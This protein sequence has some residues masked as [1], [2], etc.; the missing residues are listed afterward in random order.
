MDRWIDEANASL[1]SNE[2]EKD[3]ARLVQ[4]KQSI[5]VIS[6]LSAA[7]LLSACGG[8][9][10]G[11][12]STPT[13]PPA[14]AP[15]PTPTPTPPPAPPPPPSTE[16]QN[17]IVAVGM[18]AN[19]AY[20]KGI[21]GSGVLIAVLD[22]GIDV[23]NSEFAG[24]LSA[25]SKTFSVRTCISNCDNAGAVYET[26]TPNLQD[27]V[28]HGTAVSS[29]AAANADA[30]GIQGVAPGATIL[31]LKNA[32]G[33]SMSSLTATVLNYALDKGAFVLN[34]S[35]LVRGDFPGTCD[36]CTTT[37]RGVMDRFASTNSLYVQSVSNT[38]G[39][40][41][42]AG[43]NV[44][45]MLGDNLKNKEYFLF[46]I[47]AEIAPDQQG[48]PGILTD[49]TLAVNAHRIQ[50][51]KIGGGTELATGNSFAAP[52]IAGAAALLKQY[53]PQLGGKEISQVLLD[54][55]DAPGGTGNRSGF[56]MLNMQTAM[57]AQAPT[58]SVAQAQSISGSSVLVPSTSAPSLNS[59]GLIFSPAFGSSTAMNSFADNAGSS[60]VLDKYG[61]DFRMNVGSLAGA[62]EGAMHSIYSSL[63]IRPM[64]GMWA[65]P[66][67]GQAGLLAFSASLGSDTSAHQERIGRSGRGGL[68]S[69]ITV[70]LAFDE[71]GRVKASLSANA[72]ASVEHSTLLT[73]QMLRN[74]GFATNG[75]NIAFTLPG[76]TLRMASAKDSGVVNAQNLVNRINNGAVLG[77]RSSYNEASVTFEKGVV[78]GLTVGFGMANEERQALGATGTGAFAINGA[79]TTIARLGWQGD[80]GPVTLTGEAM[81]GMTK[82]NGG[83]GLIS[84]DGPVT[85]TGLRFQA[86]KPAF[87]GTATFG[88]T[89]P[90][91]VSRAAILYA[92]P[93]AYNWQT[94]AFD[95][96]NKR[97]SVAPSARETN[98]EVAWAKSLIGAADGSG[99]GSGYI[100]FGAA[101]GLNQANIA[102]RSNAAGWIRFGNRF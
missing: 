36:F 25:D 50:V 42:F 77:S 11:V 99:F 58:L 15:T 48:N 22:T 19:S 5:L 45:A 76:Y 12:N 84:F 51:V 7:L 95:I 32:T 39:E 8:D 10:G 85:S 87:G 1:G 17:S 66:A 49:R 37:L 100:S 94:G 93:T 31:A 72:S 44:Q 16:Y 86:D 54:T 81:Y 98:L 40:D 14:S 38:P 55:A 69:P 26:V 35:G 6:S 65:A 21:N 20:S 23:N 70:P 3:A 57:S 4:G 34:Y 92:S 46:G 53:W 2:G 29:I 78:K 102:G 9:S 33:T 24:R 43:T 27:E 64:A 18:K 47:R 52:A 74:L 80:V 30:V 59:T 97:F 88:V 101:Y 91:A 96:T 67:Q 63:Q 13:P 75:S 61:R 73:G 62:R 79:K 68:S 71:M 60:V 89:I 41:T 56:K 83:S 82:V 28:G 90:M